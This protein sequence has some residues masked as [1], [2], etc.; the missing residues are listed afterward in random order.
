MKT[1]TEYMDEAKR[2]DLINDGGENAK[3]DRD[4]TFQENVKLLT[5]K[6][7][8]AIKRL[9]KKTPNEEFFRDKCKDVQTVLN[10]YEILGK[11]LDKGEI[12]KDD[13]IAIKNKFNFLMNFCAKKNV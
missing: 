6:V 11:R 13:V 1:F 5:K 10:Q 12:H 7:N 2:T 4:K 9:K 8:S 3:I